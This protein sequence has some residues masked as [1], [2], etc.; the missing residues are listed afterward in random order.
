MDPLD[1]KGASTFT[2]ILVVIFVVAAVTIVVA[3]VAAGGI[4]NPFGEETWR[5]DAEVGVRYTWIHSAVAPDT[6]D[7]NEIDVSLRDCGYRKPKFSIL[8]LFLGD[9]FATSDGRMKAEL[10]S[11]YLVEEET[12]EFTLEGTGVVR[13]T[14]RDLEE[15]TWD[16][17]VDVFQARKACVPLVGCAIDEW[18]HRDTGTTQFSVVEG[19]DK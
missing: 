6:V 19:A 3:V 16:L 5:C 18:V 2:W 11:S 12:K 8:S 10:R 13:Y 9:V 17:R 1:Q 14:F 7:I 4:E 15:G